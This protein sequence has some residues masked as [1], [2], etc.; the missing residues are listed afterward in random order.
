MLTDGINSEDAEKTNKMSQ[1]EMSTRKIA[2]ET[3]FPCLPKDY[4]SHPNEFNQSNMELRWRKLWS[5]TDLKSY[6]YGGSFFSGQMVPMVENKSGLSRSQSFKVSRLR[7]K[8]KFLK[9]KHG[10]K[11][12][13]Q[14]QLN[15]FLKVGR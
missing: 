1:S 14:I 9:T 7:A 15:L 10:P 11:Q 6:C 13:D 2:R 3:R 4:D 5:N 12:T 8:L